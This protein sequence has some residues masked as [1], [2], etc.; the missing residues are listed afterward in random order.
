MSR[1]VCVSNRISLPRKTAA[2]G[3]LA[4]GVLSAIKRSS[5]LW[6]GWGGETTD[7]DPDDPD[8]HVRG[9][10]TYATIDLRASDLEQYYNGHANGVLWPLFH[11]LLKDFQFTRD[12]QTAYENVNRLFAQKL[13]PLLTSDDVIWV[14]DYHLIPL[15][16][17]LRELGVK[18]PI[19]FFLHIPFPHI[20][21]LRVLP[22]YAELLRDLINY[23]VI[24]FQ[25]ESDLEAFHSGIAHL[26][27]TGVQRRD[28]HVTVGDRTFIADVFPIG[29]DVEGIQNEASEARNSE[30]VRR[31]VESLVGR[32]LMIGVDRLDYSKGLVPRFTA[33]Q[34]LLEY[35]PDNLGRITYLQIAPHSRTD[36]L[37]YAEIR[38]ALEQEAGRTNGRFADADWTP[39]RYLNR[40]YPHDILMGFLRAANVG[41]VTPVRDGMNLVAKE[42][43]ASQDETDP[44]V[45]IL[46]TLAGAARELGGAIQINPYDTLGV[47][48]A[49]QTAL[50]MPLPERRERFSS[51]MAA[52]KKNDIHAW[53]QR[54][55]AALEEFIG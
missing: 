12:R 24:G 7:G 44:G 17:R 48:H 41:L 21:M 33:Y 54:F 3:G 29:V 52:L 19:G 20:E 11:Y 39:I 31:M 13:L 42:F 10:V 4:V 53:S 51:M 8:L 49:M 27:G 22:T 47:A 2:A 25:T 30:T 5:G 40:N 45:L 32:K 9:G 43:V 36:V 46:S 1:L 15:A 16:S 18:R 38:Q 35:F 23:D 55:T 26:F 14:H 6:F 28:R 50:S 37:A 34:Q